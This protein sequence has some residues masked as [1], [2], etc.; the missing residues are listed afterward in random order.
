[1]K[2]VI[3]WNK[4]S[5]KLPEQTHFHTGVFNKKTGKEI[6]NIQEDECLVIWKGKVKR[7]RYFAETQTWEGHTKD[8]V[9]EYWIKIKDI[10]PEIEK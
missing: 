3:L 7:S 6:I 1:M 10:L 2:S 4:T 9:P 8:Q 5:E